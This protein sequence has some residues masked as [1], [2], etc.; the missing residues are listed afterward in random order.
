[1]KPICVTCQR[2][3]RMS[4][5]GF[6]FIE[7][8]PGPPACDCA[9]AGN[10]EKPKQHGADVHAKT[11]AVYT[12]RDAMPGT[13]EPARWSPYKLWCGDLWECGGCGHKLI[14][15]VGRGPISEHYREDF[16]G[17]VSRYSA[18]QFTVNDC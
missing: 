10:L 13:A 12:R 2:F 8:M 15:G 17:L 7:A 6:Y 18:D 11:C 4:K 5:S 16:A 14:S 1:M 3:Y 9:A